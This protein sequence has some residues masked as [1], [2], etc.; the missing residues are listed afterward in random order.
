MT[1][2]RGTRGV[3]MACAAAILMIAMA[4]CARATG[5]NLLLNGDLAKGSEQQPDNWRTEAWVNEPAA[6]G[7]TWIH[8]QN[9]VPG[10][11]EVNA[12][13]PNDA[14]WMQSLTLAPGWYHFSA[15]VRT[16]NVGSKET[17]AT[18]SIMEDGAM[19][20]DI[21]GTTG[22]Q[23]VGLYLQVGGSGADI[24]VA[25]RVGGFG[26]LNSGRA[27]FR[28]V[29]AEKITSPPPGATPVYDLTAIRKASEPQPVG[30][31]VTL[32]ATFVVL[33]LVAYYG[34]RLFG[35]EETAPAVARAAL[36]KVR[37]KPK[38]RARR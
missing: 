9:E 38:A 19:S 16:E 12:I 18:I 25:L 22:W 5:A 34:W 35:S 3:L 29:R 6:F 11:L 27:F 26:S 24:E 17:G 31:P 4:P 21:R 2:E 28:N 13:K 33:A 37:E 36:P 1:R 10:Q 15:E 7:Y 23:T 32:W 20:P 8:P 30:H 14:R